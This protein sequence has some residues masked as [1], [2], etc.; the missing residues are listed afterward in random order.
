MNENGANKD[1]SKCPSDFGPRSNVNG[2]QARAGERSTGACAKSPRSW[3]RGTIVFRG[4]S[5]I[6]QSV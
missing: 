1:F 6:E 2:P 4:R 3:G 5:I